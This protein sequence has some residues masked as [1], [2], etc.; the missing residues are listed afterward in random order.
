MIEIKKN[1]NNFG[2]SS[3]RVHLVYFLNNY[4]GKMVKNHQNSKKTFQNLPARVF[5]KK[6]AKCL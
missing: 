1:D 3:K 2:K 4:A 5:A 6:N